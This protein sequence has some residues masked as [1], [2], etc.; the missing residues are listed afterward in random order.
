[1]N[2]SC[3][4]SNLMLSKIINKKNEWIENGN[5][6]HLELIKC[7]KTRCSKQKLQTEMLNNQL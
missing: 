2:Q 7:V 1:M 5:E 3:M 4:L 6:I